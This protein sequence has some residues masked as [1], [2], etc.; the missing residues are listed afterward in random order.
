VL[1]DDRTVIGI[2]TKMDLIEM[3]ATRKRP[4]SAQ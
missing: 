3:L 4:G 1:D 2:I